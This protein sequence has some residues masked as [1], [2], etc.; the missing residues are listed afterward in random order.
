MARLRRHLAS[1]LTVVCIVAMAG[2]ADAQGKGKGKGKEKE[3]GK[4]HHLSGKQLLGDKIKANGHQVI[5]RNGKYAATADVK[6]GKIAG[7]TVKHSEKGDV[8]VKKYKTTK[9]MAARTAASNGI[10]LVSNRTMLAQLDLGTT[11][12]GYGYVDDYGEEYI[13]WF[14]Y[15]MI[16]DGDTGA[17]DYVP[18]M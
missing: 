8:P 11:Y 4:H 15:E 12:I 10:S 17:V 2:F 18:L 7:V 6:D 3:H 1:L 9:K 13:I 16:L 5:H 14:P